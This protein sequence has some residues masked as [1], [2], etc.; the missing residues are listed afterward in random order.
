MAEDAGV[1]WA[2]FT[3][4]TFIL[5]FALVTQHL[6]DTLGIGTTFAIFAAC[7]FVAT[8]T[9]ILVLKD[10]SGL[11]KKELKQVYWSKNVRE[12]YCTTD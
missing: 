1:A 10:I 6:F 4:F 12:R 8:V 3:L 2:N 11:S 7:N 9:Y 5:I